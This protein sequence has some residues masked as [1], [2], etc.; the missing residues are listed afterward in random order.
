MEVDCLYLRDSLVIDHPCFLF[1]QY[2]L[3]NVNVF[4]IILIPRTESS[5]CFF[6][7]RIFIERVF[8][9]REALFLLSLALGEQD[10]SPLGPCDWG[11]AWLGQWAVWALYLQDYFT[12]WMVSFH[13]MMVLLHFLR[14]IKVLTGRK[15]LRDSNFGSLVWDKAWRLQ[16]LRFAEVMIVIYNFFWLMRL[17]FDKEHFMTWIVFWESLLL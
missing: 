4:I 7:S 8:E 11:G 14:G 16:N 5:G 13:Y 17:L 3:E 2:L 12:V 10:L 6:F 9:H 15:D 1:L